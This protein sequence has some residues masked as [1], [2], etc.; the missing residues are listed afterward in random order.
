MEI[1]AERQNFLLFDRMVAF[2]VQR[3][4]AV[5]LSAAE[6]YQGLSQRFSE[7]DGMYFLPD[8]IAEYDRK[9]M[10][11]REVLQLQLFIT[12]ENTA[13]QWLRQQLLKKTQ[14]SGELKP[15]FMQKIGGWLKTETLLELDELLEQNFI[16]YDGKSPVPE[17]IH[18]YLSTNWK[19]LRNLPKDDP[20]LARISHLENA[21]RPR[22]LYIH[23]D[24]S[25]INNTTRV[26]L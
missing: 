12:D 4:V 24:S 11:V 22:V 9:R 16:K 15:Q 21:K 13:I 17:Q 25:T 19:E 3:G 14:T 26:T 20:T 7:R 10:T 1:I 2:H 18:A 23:C 5:P 8:Q 6:F